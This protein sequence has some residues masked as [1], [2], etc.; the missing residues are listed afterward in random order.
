MAGLRAWHMPGSF[1]AQGEVEHWFR[2]R[3]LI[4]GKAW[5]LAFGKLAEVSSQRP[6][7]NRDWL[8]GVVWHLN[9]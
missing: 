4:A 5:K 9:N 3:D 6:E 2:C 8:L 7:A 1:C